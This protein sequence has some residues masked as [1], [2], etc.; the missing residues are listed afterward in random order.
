MKELKQIKN[1][2]E[3]SQALND[4][5]TLIDRKSK[6]RIFL[7]KNGDVEDKDGFT[8][9]KAL[10]ITD[11]TGW[12]IYEKPKWYENIPECGVLCWCWDSTTSKSKRIYLVTNYYHSKDHKFAT[13]SSFYRYATPLTREELDGFNV[14]IGEE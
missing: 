13:N 8:F 1:F 14:G 5:E 6:V 9:T 11:F 3:F 7:N 2:K 4:G 10:T 12:S